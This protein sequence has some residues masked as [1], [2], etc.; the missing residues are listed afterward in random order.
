M[1]FMM[2]IVPKGGGECLL[3][4]GVY[5]VLRIGNGYILVFVVKLLGRRLVQ[6]LRLFF[7]KLLEDWE[8]MSHVRVIHHMTLR[9]HL[10]YWDSCAHLLMTRYVGS[11]KLGIILLL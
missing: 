5:H 9:I 10:L 4:G 6:N 3:S 7:R 11:S 8:A 1:S 2:V